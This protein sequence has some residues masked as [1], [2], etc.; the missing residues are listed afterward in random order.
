MKDKKMLLIV[1][2]VVVVLSIV[3]FVGRG[4]GEAA[5]SRNRFSAARADSSASNTQSASEALRI[6][7]I[8]S[9]E[10]KQGSFSLRLKEES[11]TGGNVVYK[12][13]GGVKKTYT[14]HCSGNRV[15]EY[16]CGGLGDNIR[17]FNDLVLC[18]FDC[19]SGA[20]GGYCR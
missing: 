19:V 11:Y 18:E 1:L 15:R 17:I 6:V 4:T 5:Q 12:P 14:D 9:D 3:I 7:C 2:L 8:N 20:S 16:W 10:S 13:R